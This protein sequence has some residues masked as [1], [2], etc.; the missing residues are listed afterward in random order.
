MQRWTLFW[1]TVVTV[2]IWPKEVVSCPDFILGSVVPFWVMS[3]V[4]IY[5][6]R[7]SEIVCSN[8]WL[9]CRGHT[10]AWKNYELKKKKAL[11]LVSHFR[12]YL[13][14]YAA[15]FYPFM[16]KNFKTKHRVQFK[17]RADLNNL[18]LTPTKV[19]P[20]RG[21]GGQSTLLSGPTHHSYSF[22]RL[23]LA[24]YDLDKSTELSIDLTMYTCNC[25]LRC[26]SCINLKW[27]KKSQTLVKVHK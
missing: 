16:G 26:S 21:R 10:M 7:A 8:G 22:C 12:F 2:A 11:C 14:K 4:G 27:R 13:T 6:G 9:L 1:R 25:T 3:L 24:A 19:C 17:V 23:L 20:R 18:P 15:N 5:P